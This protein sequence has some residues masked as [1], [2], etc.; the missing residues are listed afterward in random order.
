MTKNQTIDHLI[1]TIGFE[2]IGALVREG[3]RRRMTVREIAKHL[4]IPQDNAGFFAIGHENEFPLQPGE[5][6]RLLT[7]SAGWCGNG[8][9]IEHRH[10]GVRIKKDGTPPLTFGD[11]D[12]PYNIGIVEAMRYEV[13]LTNLQEL[14]PEGATYDENGYITIPCDL[15]PSGKQLRFYC[16]HCKDW[17][18]HGI[19]G[20][21][22]GAHCHKSDSP[23][24]ARGNIYLIAPTLQ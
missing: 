17:H 7:N 16:P 5:R 18:R 9:V 13:E 14:L 11:E 1:E 8:T 2:G 22:R 3:L 21:Y 10:N 15:S 23:L 19:P 12:G 20:G 24:L 4:N 6:V